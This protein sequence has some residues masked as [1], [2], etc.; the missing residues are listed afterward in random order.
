[1][2]VNLTDEVAN[3]IIDMM[4]KQ[5]IKDY[6]RY[7]LPGRC[8]SKWV[9]ERQLSDVIRFFRGRSFWM[10]SKIDPELLMEAIY[11]RRVNNLPPFPGRKHKKKEAEFADLF[12]SRLSHYED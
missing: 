8:R 6:H 5:A 4:L 3:Y 2:D 7:C 10:Y 1:M 11:W 9:Q 12:L